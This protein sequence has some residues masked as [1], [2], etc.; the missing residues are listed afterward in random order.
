MLR[1]FGSCTLGLFRMVKSPYVSLC[2]YMVHPECQEQH[3]R[4]CICVD[5]EVEGTPCTQHACS[6]LMFMPPYHLGVVSGVGTTDVSVDLLPSLIVP[7]VSYV[8]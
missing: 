2:H 1:Q 3:H 5:R 6:Q 4:R 8:R 7:P